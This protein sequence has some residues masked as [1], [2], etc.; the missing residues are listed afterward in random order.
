MKEY[1]CFVCP[2]WLPFYLA[3]FQ[4][5]RQETIVECT[6]FHLCLEWLQYFLSK[7][8][9]CLFLLYLCH[10]KLT[11]L[12]FSSVSSGNYAESSA[13]RTGF[14]SVTT[15]MVYIYIYLC[16]MIYS[17]SQFVSM[18][19]SVWCFQPTSTT[20]H[21]THLTIKAYNGNECGKGVWIN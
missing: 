2:Q 15:G 12:E 17:E 1:A 14:I 16:C 4:K 13:K 8:D 7:R 20:W 10:I 19:E 9:F 3:Y 5:P 18:Y 11:L 21:N 6:Y